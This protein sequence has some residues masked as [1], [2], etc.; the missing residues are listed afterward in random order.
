[1]EA[2]ANR[3][4]EQLQQVEEKIVK[5][6]EQYRK[7]EEK[8]QETLVQIGLTKEAIAAP[9][10]DEAEDSEAILAPFASIL[11]DTT[12]FDQVLI[13][14][15]VATGATFTHEEGIARR[16]YVR[17]LVQYLAKAAVDNKKKAKKKD[18]SDKPR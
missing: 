7:A 13:D 2:I 16:G 17:S 11:A 12:A 15:S 18:K 4:S 9:A 1:M 14:H 10:D 5:A 8:H 6:K 3:Y